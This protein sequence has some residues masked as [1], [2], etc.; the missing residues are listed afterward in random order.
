MCGFIILFFLDIVLYSLIL[1]SQCCHTEKQDHTTI[2]LRT[3]QLCVLTPV[4][5]CPQPTEVEQARGRGGERETRKKIPPAFVRNC[6]KIVGETGGLSPPLCGRGAP[7]LSAY[8]LAAAAG[9]VVVVNR[10]LPASSADGDR[11]HHAHPRGQRNCRLDTSLV[12]VDRECRQL[13]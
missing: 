4:Q 1:F 7:L 10:S 8:I 6:W 3:I 11:H 12:G 13:Y 2:P 9:V 5:V